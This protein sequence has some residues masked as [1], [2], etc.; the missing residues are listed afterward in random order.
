MLLEILEK[1]N[2]KVVD[3]AKELGLERT[4]LFKK[5]QKFGIRKD[6]MDNK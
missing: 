6:L 5:M 2:W 3:A 1:H 4:N